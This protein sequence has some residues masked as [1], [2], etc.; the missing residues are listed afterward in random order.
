MIRSSLLRQI[1]FVRQGVV[2]GF[3]FRLDVFDHDRSSFFTSRYFL[4]FRRQ[5]GRI[6]FVAPIVGTATTFFD[7]FATSRTRLAI[8]RTFAITDGSP[9]PASEFRISV[10]V[11][12][13][14]SVPSVCVC[15]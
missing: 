3:R 14:F 9:A 15:V 8:I 5:F 6:L 11:G 4:S 12:G 1:L 10:V 2:F 13:L 7:F